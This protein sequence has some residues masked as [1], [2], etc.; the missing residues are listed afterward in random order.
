MYE[1]Q[2]KLLLEGGDA[3]PDPDLAAEG[4][5]AAGNSL[6]SAGTVGG[7]SG[8]GRGSQRINSKQVASSLD[9]NPQARQ[10]KKQNVQ[11]PNPQTSVVI[12]GL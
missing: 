7:S 4:N 1:W 11:T 3:S 8:A 12:H 5:T 9:D 6:H 2:V 10:Y